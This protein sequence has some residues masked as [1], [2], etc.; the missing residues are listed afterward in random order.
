[1][2][3]LTSIPPADLLI[4]ELN[5]RLSSPN[6][7]Q[8]K[9]L[10]GLAHHLGQKL[11]VLAADLVQHGSDPSTLPIVMPLGSRYVVLEGNRRLAAIRTL[12]NPDSIA[13]SVLPGVLKQIRKL[14]KSYQSN[15]IEALQCVVVQDRD[16]ARHWMELRH[17]G[18]HGGAG[19]LKWSADE[20][21]RFKARSG[22][23]PLQTQVLDFLQ[24][25]GDL[26][27]D[28]RREVPTSSLKRLLQTPA[29]R[30]RLGLELTNKEISLLGDEARVAK[31]LM[32]VIKDLASGK[33]KVS[34]IYTKEQRDKYA[35][36]IPADLAVPAT[37]PSGHG[38]AAS[39]AG[40]GTKPKPTT[41]KLPKKRDKLI[42]RDCVLNIP[43]GRARDIEVELRKLSLEAHTNAVGVLF[44]VFLELTV[45]SFI[46]KAT[47]PGVTVDSALQKK[48]EA[49]ASNLIAA[50]RLTPK[51]AIPVRR[52]CQKDSFLAP[53]ITL[54]HQYVH[55]PYVFPAPGDLR[56]NWDSLQPFVAAVWAP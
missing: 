8:H 31:A 6:A 19:V 15:P 40:T 26:T 13:A 14:S 16:E 1:M 38:V 25:R 34:D 20:I 35:S 29:V 48:M 24:K 33:T 21:D 44:R 51:Q 18:E 28:A 9:A 32:Y 41:G 45:D 12:E 11:A 7:G 37:Q 43:T 49:T 47:P 5:P 46:E 17:T 3:E 54:M 10:N 30:T 23:A 4:D 39:A 55:N 56:S 22:H 42:P 53:S 2:P 27:E 50:K 52:A 36:N